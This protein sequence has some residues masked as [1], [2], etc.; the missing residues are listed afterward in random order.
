VPRDPSRKAKRKA[1]REYEIDDDLAELASVLD[2]NRT[3]Y[4]L[5]GWL[6]VPWR[7]GFC[8]AR[9]PLD[10]WDAWADHKAPRLANTLRL[11]LQ[12][13]DIDPAVYET[14][15]EVIAEAGVLHYGGDRWARL[16]QTAGRCIQLQIA[17]SSGGGCVYNDVLRTSLEIVDRRGESQDLTEIMLN[18]R[19]LDAIGTVAQ[20]Q[21]N[22]F[23]RERRAFVIA[24]KRGLYQAA[25]SIPF[26]GGRKCQ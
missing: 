15:E 19:C 26:V 9:V 18:A 8:A 25:Y 16:I 1:P 2:D 5:Q 20:L 14:A 21:N 12:G 3:V 24:W 13:S 10:I 7:S 17:R 23:D 22:A 6:S 4:N 11:L